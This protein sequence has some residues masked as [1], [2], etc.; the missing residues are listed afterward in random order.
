MSC[1]KWVSRCTPF[2]LNSVRGR[3]I[4]VR[5]AK[6]DET[7][8]TLDSKDRKLTE[9]MLVI[10]DAEGATGLAGIMGGEDSEITDKTELVLFESACFDGANIRI[11]GRSLGMR[12]EAQGQIRSAA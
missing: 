7:M 3:Q 9:N 11:S 1:W 12:T 5:R 8:M 2:D 10:A 6:P 4:I